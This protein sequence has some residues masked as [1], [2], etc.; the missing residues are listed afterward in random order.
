M[1][2]YSGQDEG[3]HILQHRFITIFTYHPSRTLLLVVANLHVNIY[4]CSGPQKDAGALEIRR[5][6]GKLL[7]LQL[8]LGGVQPAAG[9]ASLRDRIAPGRQR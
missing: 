5:S 6:A 7:T 2:G 4:Y 8:Q 3:R 9:R 1:S